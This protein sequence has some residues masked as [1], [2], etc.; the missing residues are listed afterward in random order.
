MYV[1]KHA[2]WM[3]EMPM[4]G[5]IPLQQIRALVDLVPRFGEKADRHLTKMNS[6]S[7]SS[8]FWLNKYLDKEL[9]Y[10]LDT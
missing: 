9:F 2:T 3:N 7:Y 4:G 10:A 6:L 8:E 5:I 1:L